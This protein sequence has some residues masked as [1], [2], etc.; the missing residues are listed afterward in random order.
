MNT[1]SFLPEERDNDEIKNDNQLR[2]KKQKLQKKIKKYQ[3]NPSDDLLEEINILKI[4]IREYEESKQTYIP[5]KKKKK[6]EEKNSDSDD[7]RSI[8]FM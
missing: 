4:E 1:F 3:D 6:I 8:L 2:N 5:K 7:L